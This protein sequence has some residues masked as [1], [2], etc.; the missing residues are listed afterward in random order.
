MPQ[1]F[2]VQVGKLVLNFVTP[3]ISPEELHRREDAG[4]I[5]NPR[6]A[7]RIVQRYFDILRGDHSRGEVNS[8]KSRDF[9]MA[10]VGSFQWQVDGVDL[11]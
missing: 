5:I 6:E 7:Q 4:E 10:R 8:I 1:F 9:I 11:G 3:P 2:T